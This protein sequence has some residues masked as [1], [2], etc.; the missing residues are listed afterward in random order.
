MWDFHCPW[1]DKVCAQ[2][3]IEDEVKYCGS[4]L[5]ENR[6]VLMKKCPYDK[7]P[8]TERNVKKWKR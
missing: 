1:G 8:V 2:A 6:I 5:G 4:Q 7:T 3:F